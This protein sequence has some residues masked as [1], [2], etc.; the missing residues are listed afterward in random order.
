MALPKAVQKG[1]EVALERAA[2]KLFADMQTNYP[3]YA[4]QIP[5][6]SAYISFGGNR[7]EVGFTD[8]QVKDLDGGVEGRPIM[9]VYKQRVR[10][11]TRKL[12]SGRT[13]QV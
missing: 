4:D 8:P 1:L 12:Q 5:K 10:R 6:S 7:I 11:H 2:K 9:G 13:I 3:D